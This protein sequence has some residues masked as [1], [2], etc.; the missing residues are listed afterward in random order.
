MFKPQRTQEDNEVQHF[1]LNQP[2][3]DIA[4]QIAAEQSDPLDYFLNDPQAASAWCTANDADN[5]IGNMA[6]ASTGNI[7]Y[8]PVCSHWFYNKSGLV[9][10]SFTEAANNSSPNISV[11]PSTPGDIETTPNTTAT[12]AANDIGTAAA[13]S[14]SVTTNAASKS[15]WTPFSAIDSQR[16]QQCL[17]T[18]TTVCAS[19]GGRYDV[20]LQQRRRV[21]VYWE[22]TGEEV[23]RCSWF[24]R[25]S[26]SRLVP[27]EEDVAERLEAEYRQAA[28]LG[29]W[30][31]KVTLSGGD[32]VVLHGPNVMVQFSKAQTP[33]VDSWT[34][35]TAAPV[36][37]NRP[38]I[39]KRGLEEFT[40]DEGESE[41]VDH[42]M[43]MVH[44]IGA[45]CDLKFRT[46]EQV[47]EYVRYN[48]G[49]CS[50]RI[51]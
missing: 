46:V 19:N 40:I 30:N 45:A 26:D 15:E 2:S 27:Y 33:S 48:T 41:Q 17:E 51:V 22:A 43:F 34:E 29:R 39:V 12:A 23:R 24:Y 8:R 49:L 35:N 21:P 1:L 4:A 20:H 25:G 18:G 36:A 28:E 6:T 11:G 37:G 9:S 31:R 44:G 38:R 13:S 7:A 42:L 16:L 47:G 5:N 10:G 14:T 50:K 3:N 32:T